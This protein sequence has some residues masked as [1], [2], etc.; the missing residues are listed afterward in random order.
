MAEAY[1][2]VIESNVTSNQQ[3]VPI[4]GNNTESKNTKQKEVSSN[5]TAKSIVGFVAYKKFVAPVIQQGIQSY[6]GTV[7]LR[8]GNAER[9]QRAESMLNLAS[10]GINLAESVWMGAKMGGAYGAVAAAVVSVGQ[11]VMD[12]YKKQQNLAYNNVLEQQTI[13]MLNIRSGAINGNR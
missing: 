13:D 7:Q 9:Q 4:A 11:S 2:I 3:K 12:I 1:K 8:T 6:I 5:N 10:R